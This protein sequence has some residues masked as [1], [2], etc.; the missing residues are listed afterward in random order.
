MCGI[1]GIFSKEL[2]LREDLIENF[3]SKTNQILEHRGPDDR[4]FYISKD[5]NLILTHRRLSIIDLTDKG[6]QPMTNEDKTLWLT[7]NGEIYNF[8]NLKEDLI[9][10]GHQFKSQADSEVILH[11]YEEYKEKSFSLLRGM[12][13]FGLWDDR[14]KELYWVRDRFGIKPLYYYEDDRL[15]IFSSEVK[16]FKNINLIVNELN[17]KAIIG[18]LIFGYVPEDLTTVKGVYSLPAG[19]YMVLSKEFRKIIKYYE[20]DFLKKNNP[21]NIYKD[22]RRILEESINIH[23][24]SDAPLGVFLSGGIDSSGLVAL[25]SKFKKESLVTLSLIFKEREFSEEVYQSIVK[26]KYNT[27]HH[28]IEL[29]SDDFRQEIPFIL[30]AMDQPTVDG[31]NTYFVSKAAKQAGLKTVLSGLGGDEVFCGYNSFKFIHILKNIQSLPKMM[32]FSFSSSLGL[33]PDKFKKISYLL[34]E[35]PLSLY[36]TIRGLFYIN[37]VAE[38]LNIDKKEIQ[39]YLK[40]FTL[41]LILYKMNP[42]DFLQYMEINFYLKGQ[43]LKDIDFMSMCHSIETRVPYLDHILVEYIKDLDPKLKINRNICKPLLANSLKDLLPKEII[44]RKKQSFVFP[45]SVWLKNYQKQ[46]E[47]LIF[48]KTRINKDYAYKLCKDFKNNRIHWSKFWTLV[49]LNQWLN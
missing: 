48:E 28:Q 33:L 4:G 35:D 42:I 34:E 10:K 16:L 14:R 38:I 1:A 41:P 8:L 12:F 19:S 32:R 27:H 17:L 23:L 9:K 30:E 7:F 21:V 25:A 3:I 20:L 2:P 46:L 6:H 24:I 37:D 18:F 26:E 31:I 5:K 49:V 22:I 29:T 45:F 44:H 13:A 47:D 15:A 36:L 11:L 40:S 39:D 43:L